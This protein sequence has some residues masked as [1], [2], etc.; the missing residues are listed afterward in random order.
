MVDLEKDYYDELQLAMQVR[1]D[2][3]S[4]SATV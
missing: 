4:S 1:G 3:M 2:N